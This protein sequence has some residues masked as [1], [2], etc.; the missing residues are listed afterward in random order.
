MIRYIVSQIKTHRYKILLVAALIIIIVSL[1]P[2]LLDNDVHVAP[3]TIPPVT[4]ISDKNGNLLAVIRSQELKILE[5]KAIIDSLA[6]AIRVKPSAIKAVDRYIQH[7]DTVIRTEVVY[8]R[9]QDSVVIDKSDNY[10]TLHVVGRD[11]GISEI[12]LKHID[13]LWR[14]QVDHRP[15]FKPPYTQIIMRNSSPYNTI[16]H[17][18]SLTI[19]QPRTLL[20]IGPCIGWDFLSRNPVLGIGIQV[21]ILKISK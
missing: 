5:H 8:Q 15:L 16:V 14:T 6:N 11:S 12:V 17:G 1:R 13:T 4:T 7:T 3:S 21:P 2:V 18:S 20:T 10:I 9:Y 19:R